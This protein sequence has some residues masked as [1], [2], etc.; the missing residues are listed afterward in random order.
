MQTKTRRGDWFQ[1]HTGIQFYPLD[2]QP[3][4]ICIDDIAHALSKICR[5]GGHTKEFYSVAQHSVIV[6]NIVPPHLAL[7]GLMHDATEAYI[8]DVVRPLKY[9]LPD[10]IQIEQRLWE[11][12]AERFNLPSV[13]PPEIKHA[14]NRALVT[15][16]RDLLA[17]Q[18]QWGAW[19]KDYAP[20]EWKIKP[21]PPVIAESLF[22]LRFAE[23]MAQN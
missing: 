15:E 7:T 20:I 19:T 22:S 14:D 10:Y 3:E 23:L 8:G 1:T 17:V 16:R 21:Q 13:L 5:F 6:S 11:V 4:D 12:I 2:P 9:S 18:R